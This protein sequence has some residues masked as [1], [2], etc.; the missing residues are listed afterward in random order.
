MANLKSSKKDIR[1]I[2]T[3]T[4]RNNAR[5]TAIDILGRQLKK[6]VADKKTKEA[7]ELLVKYY[8]AVD[9]A[10]SRKVI[11]KNTAARRKSAAAKLLLSK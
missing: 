8:K 5:R 1:R 7:K 2:A 11:E 4:A 6:A 3:R 9:K 10:A